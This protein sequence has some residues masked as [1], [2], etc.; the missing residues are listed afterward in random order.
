MK[1]VLSVCFLFFF[2]STFVFANDRMIEDKQN[3]LTEQKENKRRSLIFTLKQDQ[4]LRHRWFYGW[5]VGLGALTIGH[6]SVVFS[7]NHD[8]TRVEN[9]VAAIASIIGMGG[10]FISPLAPFQ[11]DDWDES[12]SNEHLEKI[13]RKR[14]RNESDAK[15]IFEHILCF[16]IAAG[17]GMYLWKKED[18]PLSAGMTFGLNLL[19]GELQIWTAP[20]FAKT[21]WQT[22]HPELAP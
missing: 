8:E 1:H 15:G 3:Q 11:E 22:R 10:T 19:L 4:K 5:T 6:T 17:S 2:T 7:A 13:L 12:F 18:Q 16:A 20:T 14:A 9:G 21:W